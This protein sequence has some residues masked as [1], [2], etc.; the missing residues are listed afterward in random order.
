M[1]QLPPNFILMN[2]DC[3]MLIEAV[4][5]KNDIWFK[6]AKFEKKTE[7]I[8][9]KKNKTMVMLDLVQR[10]ERC[11]TVEYDALLRIVKTH[12]KIACTCISQI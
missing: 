4:A 5:I 1:G 7:Q 10:T 6:A 11:Q 2:R 8:K 9:G 3:L 12:Q